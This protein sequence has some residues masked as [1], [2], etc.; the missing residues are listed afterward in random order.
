MFDETSFGKL[1]VVGRDSEAVLQRLCTA[2][3]AVEAGPD[4]LH[5]H[6]QRARRIRGGRDDH[7]PGRR[8]LPARDERGV[9]GAR[10]GRGSSGIFASAEHVSVVDVSSAY[11]VLGVMGPASRA[12][13]GPAQLGRSV[14]RR[15]PL[16]HEQGDLRRVRHGAGHPPHLRGG[17]RVGAV[18]ADRVRRRRLRGPA[19]RRC[20][21]R[22]RRRRVLR[23]QQ[24]PA[25]QGVSSLRLRPQPGLHAA[26]GGPAFHLQAQDADRLHRP[27]ARS[28]RPSPRGRAGGS[29]PSGSAI[30]TLML[31]GGELVLHDGVPAGQVTS[32]AWS[33]TCGS[34]VGLA[35]VWRSGPWSRRSGRPGHRHLGGRGG[36]CGT[37]STCS[38][39][40]STIPRRPGSGVEP[41][42]RSGCVASSPGRPSRLA[43]AGNVATMPRDGAS[44]VT[45]R[46]SA[47]SASACDRSARYRP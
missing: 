35:Y 36:R 26:R 7:P 31:W 44:R 38:P 13:A 47:V 30:P 43:S 34:A 8:S 1:L 24:P 14:D 41:A 19:G 37:R 45:S 33:S 29:S 16:R 39:G 10:R 5:R 11:A 18:R 17:A 12:I 23:H 28:S 32:A 4:R 6:A 15:V 20:R 46:P 40:R 9:A 21:P 42:L 3:V 25:R 22:P 2:D 27:G